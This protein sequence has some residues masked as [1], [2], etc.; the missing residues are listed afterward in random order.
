[1]ARKPSVKAGS[2]SLDLLDL[3]ITQLDLA[4]HRPNINAYRPYP[5]QQ[6]FHECTYTGRYMS[7]GNRAGKTTAA[8]I[9]CIWFG[10]N[11]HP[12]QERPAH[13]GH[14]AIKM[15]WVVVDIDKG[16]HG[17]V[18]P[19]LRRWCTASM[20]INGSFEDSWNNSTLT[21]TFAN[22]STIQFLTHGMELDKHGGVAMHIIYFDEIP[23]QSV[24]NENLMR[25]VDYDGK[26]VIA[27]TAV[28]GMEWT[29]ELLWEPAK[30]GKIDYVGT[31]E[32]SQKDNPYLA[33][34]L[35]ARGKFYV[36]MDENER[37]IREE[38]AFVPRA[39]RVFPAWNIHDH[40]LDEHFI[41]DP[42]KWRIYTTTDFGYN[43][44]T[45]WLWHAVHPDGRIYT[46][47]E[48]YK[49][50]M[51]V[52]QHAVAVKDREAFMPHLNPDDVIRVGDPAGK[53]R[54]GVTGTSYIT[55]Y[56]NAGLYIGTEGIP[57]EV[58]I[59][60]E[61]MQ[62]YIRLERR[63]GWGSNKPRWMI[64]PACENLIREMKKLRWASFESQKRAFDQNKKEEVHKKDDHAFDSTRYLF[65]LMP[66]LEPTVEEVIEKMADEGVYLD[67]QQAIAT[68]RADDRVVFI[69]DE[70]DRWETEIL[71]DLEVY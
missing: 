64:S 47:A 55:E 9:D 23:P 40:V 49:S 59:G 28:G 11:T 41:P 43:N 38:G 14:G 51:T 31:F 45:A 25:L 7:A 21:F 26:W 24:F 65:T 30:E 70:K 33:T 71:E 13:W 34:Q 32:L 53:Q 62:Q 42:R 16:V 22:G 35:E 61:K 27:A 66:D 5:A 36:G 6:A 48:H 1:M 67:Y 17:I 52:L 68:L 69:D 58:S 57:H 44:P 12:F 50:E 15:R 63:N 18:L 39:G 19:E 56:A 60:I 4:I 8:V 3:A 54:N 2:S 46:F 29:Y 37:K 20:L 10:T